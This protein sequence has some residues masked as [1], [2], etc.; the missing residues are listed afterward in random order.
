MIST[1]SL[2]M[3]NIGG[4]SFSHYASKS[5]LFSNFILDNN[6][7]DLGFSGSWFTWCNSQ[8]ALAR[9]WAR[10]DRFLA[11][12]LWIL[13]FQEFSNIHLLWTIFYHSPFFSELTNLPITT[14]KVIVLTIFSLNMKVAMKVLSKLGRL[15]LAPHRYSPF[16]RRSLVP[17]IT[18]SNGRNQIVAT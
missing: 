12:S 14:I 10:L 13:D 8:T 6:L 15:A 11:N 16:R 7:F 17:N 4:E 18:F 9:R 3:R 1:P 2:A 5:T